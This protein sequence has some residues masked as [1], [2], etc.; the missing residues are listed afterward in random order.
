MTT[1][2]DMSASPSAGLEIR[3]CSSA[4]REEQARLFNACFKKQIA[5]RE[6]AWRYDEGPHGASQS[7]VT[8]DASGLALSGYACNPRRVLCRG[9]HATAVGQTGDVMT[10]PSA[11][12]R[13]LFSD[14]DRACM[15][16]TAAAGWTAVFGLPNRTSAPIFA[17][18]LGWNVVGRIRPHTFLLAR[19]ARA[20]AVRRR[21]GRL[22]GLVAPLSARRCARARSALAR[23]GVGV[24]VERAALFPREVGALGLEVARRYD[25]MVQRDADYLDWRFARNPSGLHRILVARRGADVRGYAVVQTPRQEGGVGYF[26]DLLAED[27]AVRAALLDAGLHELEAAGAAAV[28]ATAVDGS[29]WQGELVRAGFLWPRA[30][31]HMIVISYVHAPEHPVARAMLDARTWYLTDGDRDDATMG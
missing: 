5:A 7:F 29:W 17:G 14:L 11:R 27:A 30:Q 1:T 21:E 31:N 12:G 22:A 15:R 26:V 8:R 25:W 9:E 4:D 19:D 28:E 6:L 10:H 13:G 3:A 2:S 23:L 16:S 24:G 18:K 20:R